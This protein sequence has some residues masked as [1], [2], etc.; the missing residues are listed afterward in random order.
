[1]AWLEYGCER[2][3]SVGVT[4]AMVVNAMGAD[5]VLAW[6]RSHEAST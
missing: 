3:S 6:T 2:G 5:D 4:A 1:M